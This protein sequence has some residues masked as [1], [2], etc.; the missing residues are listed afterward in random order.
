MRIKKTKKIDQKLLQGYFASSFQG[1]LIAE[2]VKALVGT[3]RISV[4]ELVSELLPRAAS[5]AIAPLSSYQVGAICRGVSGNLYFGANIEFIGEPLHST[6]HAEQASIAN[7]ISKGE[8][9]IK[10]ITVTAMPCGHCRQ[11][12][13]EL[14]TA[15]ELK[16]FVIGQE[17]I[18][19]SDLLPDAF[20]PADLNIEG[21]LM[22][23]QTHDLRLENPSSDKVIQKA[24]RAAAVS[25]APYSNC[26]S[27]VALETNSGEIF[28]GSYAENAAFNPSLLPLQA[29]MVNMIMA[30]NS[31]ND[32]SKAVLVQSKKQKIDFAEITRRTLKSVSNAQL[33]IEYT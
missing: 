7:A 6:V 33:A 15:R 23:P 8:N 20:G 25:Y 13:N 4:E 18:L 27:G 19:F 30:G 1:F 17:P 2:E 24:L 21:R 10:A 14:N 9:G 3:L 29:A 28:T 26:Y 31:F 16:I 32:I 12:I 5:C 11:F 22:D